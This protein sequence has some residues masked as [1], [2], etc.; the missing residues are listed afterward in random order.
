RYAINCDKI[1]NEL[2]WQQKMSFEE[3]LRKTVKWYLDNREWVETI[4]S[5]EYK[6]W[7][8]KNYSHR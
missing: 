6:K 4:R 7:L 3:G 8:K 1:K 5:G 2:G